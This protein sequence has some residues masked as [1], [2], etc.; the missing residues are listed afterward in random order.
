MNDYLRG[1]NDALRLANERPTAFAFSV[2]DKIKALM[3]AEEKR[4]EPIKRENDHIR[5]ALKPRWA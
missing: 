3:D 1:L 5:N 2:A 4:L